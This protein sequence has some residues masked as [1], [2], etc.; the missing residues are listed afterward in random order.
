MISLRFDVPVEPDADEAREWLINELAKSPYQAAKPTLFDQIAKAIQDWLNSLTIGEA[1]GPPAL[2]IG[3]LLIVLVAAI[4]VA[5]IIFGIPRLNRRSK[6]SGSLFGEDDERSAESMRRDAEDAASR[7]DFSTAIAEMFRSI[8]RGLAERT[9]LSTLPGTT[10]FGFAR[11]AGE[12]FPA[13]ADRLTVAA[14]SFDDVRYLGRP[15][16]QEQFAQVAQL[17][18]EL[19]TLKT[20]LAPAPPT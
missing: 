19:R 4:V 6:V 18:R 9:I 7:G 1:Q 20:Q 10:A 5:I 15:G 8:A 2:G 3:I 16:T 11:N 13:Q 14:G 17:E 12:N